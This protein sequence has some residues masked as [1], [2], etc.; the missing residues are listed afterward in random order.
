MAHS[1]L[2]HLHSR[3]SCLSLHP[4]GPSTSAPTPLH[5]GSTKTTPQLLNSACTSV[6]SH[7][8]PQTVHLLLA[9][10]PFYLLHLHTSLPLLFFQSNRVCKT[11]L[12]ERRDTLLLARNMPGV[13][14]SQFH[15][16][17]RSHYFLDSSSETFCNIF[18][19]KSFL[20]YIT[21]KIPNIASLANKW[22]S[23]K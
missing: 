8:V 18:S 10:P 1:S 2:P 23:L 4:S 22:N 9:P 6:P 19:L 11:A 15:P 20:F 13:I 16:P 3:A 14:F 7:L 12:R 5:R 21:C 17:P